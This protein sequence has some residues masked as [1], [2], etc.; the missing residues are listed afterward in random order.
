MAGEAD[1]FRIG[2]LLKLAGRRPMPAPGHA[3]AARAAARAEWVRVV[4]R[5]AWRVSLWRLSAA[6]LVTAASAV[7]I[8]VRVGP[9]PSVAPVGPIA[10]VQTV[11]GTMFVTSIDEGRRSVVDAGT[12]LRPGDRI[13]TANRA[14]AAFALDANVS[15]RLDQSSSVV[16]ESSDRLSLERGALYV[17]ARVAPRGIGV[18]VDTPFGT[19]RHV[20]TQFEARLRDGALRIR[21][22]EGTVAIEQGTLRWTTRAGERLVVVRDRPPEREPIETFGQDWAWIEAL[23]QPFTLES[24][25]VPEFL[26][27]AARELG[28]RWEYENSTVGRRADRIVLHGSVEGLHP[29]EA[30]AAVL[31]TCGLTSRRVGSRLVI[32]AA[33]H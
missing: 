27:W 18:R 5:R 30:L 31:P 22:R 10:T 13:E 32:S 29:E 28:L 6:A 25:T 2:E 21:V 12:P 7:A 17:D 3:E 33:T 1:D 23:A 16:L 24:A 20:G 14:R 19:V 8:W 11:I 26:N 9:P 15:V 4:E